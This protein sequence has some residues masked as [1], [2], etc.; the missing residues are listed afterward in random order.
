M[1]LVLFVS[2]G[3]EQEENE[4]LK[5]S[6]TQQNTAQ[7]AF[8]GLHAFI[9][10]FLYFY[11]PHSGLITFLFIISLQHSTVTFII[12]IYFSNKKVLTKISCFIFKSQ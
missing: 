2:L 6:D 10:I 9:L 8:R 4:V 12:L 1:F 7:V 11:L 5:H 3:A